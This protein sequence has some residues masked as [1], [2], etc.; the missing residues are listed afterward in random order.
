[1]VLRRRAEQIVSVL[2][3]LAV[4]FIPLA[5]A[6]PRLYPW[7]HAQTALI[8]RG[9]AHFHALVAAKGAYLNVPFFVIRSV[10]YWVC[11]IVLAELLR[12]ASLEQD[13]NP[14]PAVMRRIRVVS[15]VGLP[16]FAITVSFASF[17]W[18]MSLTPAWY[19]TV[20][21]VYYY[22]SGMVAAMGLLALVAW[23]A[24]TEGSGRLSQVLEPDHVHAI[25]KLTITF[26]LFWVYIG[27][28]QLIVIWSGNVP[29]EVSWYVTRLRGGWRVVAMVLLFGG[30]A[31]PFCLLLIR[32]IKRR[33][34]AMA[35]I[36]AWLVLMHYLNV[37]WMAMP[38][39]GGG[40]ASFIWCDAAALLFVAAAS[41]LVWKWRCAGEPAV[42]QSDP[43]LRES[44][45]YTTE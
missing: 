41:T 14:T 21:G 17:D 27:Y 42:V 12:R 7:T 3:V 22:A 34:A 19:S 45:M 40:S 20:F 31:V 13:S 29:V 23:Y 36:G 6:M 18:L 28:S 10:F 44:V 9:D 39:Y 24:R 35:L 32:A 8:G 4:L 33:A 11:W 1:V 30:F 16:L 43:A 25:A 26:L 37:Y 5:I 38:E 15:A 2:P